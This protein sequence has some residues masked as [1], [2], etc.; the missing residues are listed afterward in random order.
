MNN[1]KN[2]FAKYQINS[3]RIL[4]DI[5]G[6]NQSPTVVVLAGILN[7]LKIVNKKRD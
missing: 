4:G 2:N 7:A 6:S 5:T 1:T 3:N